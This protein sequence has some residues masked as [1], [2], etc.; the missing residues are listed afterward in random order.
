MGTKRNGQ[1]W[2][3]DLVWGPSGEFTV[4]HTDG[5]GFGTITQKAKTDT[6]LLDV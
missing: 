2:Q 5:K 1:P 4:K 3:Q 6:R